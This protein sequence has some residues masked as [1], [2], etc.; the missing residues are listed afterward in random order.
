MEWASVAA[1][2]RKR[3]YFIILIIQLLVF[4]RVGLRSLKSV[5]SLRL[6]K[7]D[8]SQAL[9]HLEFPEVTTM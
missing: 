9:A 7:V 3:K 1:R 8:F 5:Q 6:K 4:N 2:L